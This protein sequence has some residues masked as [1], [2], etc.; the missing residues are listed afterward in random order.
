MGSSFPPFTPI[1]TLTGGSP[2]GSILTATANYP[3]IF[4]FTR[5]GATILQ[6][7]GVMNPTTELCSAAYTTVAADFGASG[8]LID[9]GAVPIAPALSE[10]ALASIIAPYAVKT[11]AALTA[12]LASVS[13]P[14]FVAST[15]QTGSKEILVDTTTTYQTMLGFGAAM[16]ESSAY[17]LM[18]NM[19]ASQRASMLQ[20]LFGTTG[21]STMRLPAADADFC[22]RYSTSNTLG[23][24]VSY[25]DSASDDGLAG[26]TTAPRS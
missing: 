3:A 2:V 25:D 10:P 12:P 17:V 23:S 15:G 6:V 21:L 19:T 22:L 8:H 11:D 4:T 20:D 26:F 5:D 7:V 13:M 16:T 9:V 1:V 18:T 24:F 14:A